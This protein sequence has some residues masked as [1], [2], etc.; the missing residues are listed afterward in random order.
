MHDVKKRSNK[1]PIAIAIFGI[2]LELTAIWLL[3]TKRI[4]V[5]TASPLIMAG[6]FL[7]FVPI[8]VVARRARRTPKK[9]DEV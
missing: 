6:M 5:S 3:A 9:R 2:A 7:A 8:F 4:P 1:L